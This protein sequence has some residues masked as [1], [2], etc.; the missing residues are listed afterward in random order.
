MSGI[1]PPSTDTFAGFPAYIETPTVGRVDI[2]TAA[3]PAAPSRADIQSPSTGITPSAATNAARTTYP[4]HRRAPARASTQNTGPGRKAMA[5]A[6]QGSPQRRPREI[7]EE[8]GTKIK[9][10]PHRA[11][12]NG[13]RARGG[14]RALEPRAGPGRTALL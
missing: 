5:H 2:K 6:P 14:A 11:G 10:D 4:R 1:G 8:P 9:G 13:G 3:G 7:R 12:Q